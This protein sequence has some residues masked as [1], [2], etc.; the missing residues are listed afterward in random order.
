MKI[1][2][3]SI[4]FRIQ[5]NPLEIGEKETAS[6]FDECR[7]DPRLMEVM[8]EFIRD[9]WW[10]LNPSILNAALKR[11]RTQGA[12]KPSLLAIFKNCLFPNDETKKEFT[13]WYERVNVGLRTP[14]SPQLFYIGLNKIGSRSMN[15]E[16]EEAL[17]YFKK[18]NF[19]AKDP[20]FNKGIPGTVKIKSTLLKDER[21][22]PYLST[23]NDLA[24]QIKL[25]KSSLHLKNTEIIEALGINRMFLSKILKNDL[26]GI[27]A[28]YLLKKTTLIRS[29]Y[30]KIFKST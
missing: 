15:R 16:V 10:N 23:K 20:P 4:Y 22:D 14:K 18:Y 8:T 25:L 13:H 3:G 11:N 17:P 1:N 5:N 19:F 6:L 2:D 21:I 7:L 29:R 9:F 24:H 27:S 12:I 26:T 30:P 28:D